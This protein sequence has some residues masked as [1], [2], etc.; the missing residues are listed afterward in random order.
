MGPSVTN[1]KMDEKELQ[2]YLHDVLNENYYDNS[3]Y[4][5]N[6]NNIKRLLKRH[7]E[8]YYNPDLIWSLVVFQNFLRNLN[9]KFFYEFKKFNNFFP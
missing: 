8:E 6:F 1:S 4:Y 5:L 2:P 9:F 3:K 7:K